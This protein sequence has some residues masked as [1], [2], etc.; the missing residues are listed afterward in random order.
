MVLAA[1]LS[2]I[3]IWDRLSGGDSLEIVG[4]KKVR[5]HLLDLSAPTPLSLKPG[6]DGS[7]GI[8]CQPFST[9]S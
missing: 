3:G 6:L 5:A 4:P 2:K 8:L 1:Y 7:F 9:F